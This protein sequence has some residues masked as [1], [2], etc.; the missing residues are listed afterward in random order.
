MVDK[1]FPNVISAQS[2]VDLSIFGDGDEEEVDVDLDDR[3][4]PLCPQCLKP[5]KDPKK[6]LECGLVLGRP[7]NLDKNPA[8][9]HRSLQRD[10]D[11]FMMPRN[12]HKGPR[13]YGLGSDLER[14]EDQGMDFE[15]AA[16]PKRKL[17]RLSQV[18]PVEK[19]EE[20][21]IEDLLKAI[22]G[23]DPLAGL[24]RGE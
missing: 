12:K 20:P 22:F 13:D 3:T 2:G 11:D 10:M 19:A 21:S 7:A 5:L 6:C 14:M 8:E 15:I 17:V 24:T 9:R 23:D 1:R 18:A 16:A 4:L